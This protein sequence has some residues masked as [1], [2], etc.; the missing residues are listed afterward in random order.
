MKLNIGGTEAKDGWK[1]LNIQSA[2][3]VDFVGSCIDLSQFQNESFSE[4][5][6]SHVLEH[7]SHR[8]DLQAVVGEC[9]RILEPDCQLKISVPDMVTLCR[10]FSA[11]N[12]TVA[13]RYD[14]MLIMFGG[15]VDEYDFHHVGIWEEFLAHYL[16]QFG[17]TSFE[18]V[19]VFGLFDDFSEYRVAGELISLNMV[20]TK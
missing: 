15:Q 8:N 20:A 16:N 18:R 17:F 5:Y 12:A 9:H 14:L 2:P 10:L 4:V 7:L 13:S 6:A 3:N 11:E 1:I 19:D